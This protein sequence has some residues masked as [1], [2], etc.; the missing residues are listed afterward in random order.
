MSLTVNLNLHVVCRQKISFITFKYY[1]NRHIRVILIIYQVIVSSFLI[2]MSCY[3]SY[4]FSLH[5]RVKQ[6]QKTKQFYVKVKSS[7]FLNI[8]LSYFVNVI[9]YNSMFK[10]SKQKRFRYEIWY[11]SREQDQKFFFLRG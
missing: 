9:V 5:P 2:W 10:K 6:Q 1:P 7:F 8:H 11:K 4:P 3:K